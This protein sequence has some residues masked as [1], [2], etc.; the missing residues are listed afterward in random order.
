MPGQVHVDL[1]SLWH[2]EVTL[3]G[4]YAYGVEAVPDGDAAAPV[5]TFDL[6]FEIVAAER[7]R[8]ARLRPLPARPLR[9]GRRPRRLR[10]AGGAP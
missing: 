9:G 6:A 5:R 3:A 2:R 4:A 1:A 10:P 8:P 7:T